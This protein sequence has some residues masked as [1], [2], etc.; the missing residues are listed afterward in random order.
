VGFLA[1]IALRLA[2]PAN[3][4]FSVEAAT[5]IVEVKL[6]AHIELRWQVDGAIVCARDELKL[7]QHYRL[8]SADNPCGSR[9]WRAWRIPDPEQVI[10]LD[11]DSVATMQAQ[12]LG[13]FAISLRSSDERS[14]GGYSV[15]GIVDDVDI[16]A[17]LNLIWPTVPARSLTLPFTGETTLGRAVSWSGSR[18]LLSGSAAVFTSDESADKRSMVEEATLMLGDQV[19]LGPPKPGSPW[20]KGFVR[21]SD[22]DDFMQVVAFGRASSLRIERFG[23]SGYDFK[24]GLIRKVAADP[25]IAFW[26]SIL[27]AYMTL[28]LGLQ[29]FVGERHEADAEQR[30]TKL[31]QRFSRWIRNR[32]VK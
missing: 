7:P 22:G 23:E 14:L 15:I 13:G 5:Q 1:F 18:M 2:L 6:P 21:M 31:L 17:S 28:I 19:R 27:A 25:R 11:G 12:P 32:P 8:T 9:A 16:G 3:W 10:R 4:Q 24:P 30:A 29:P 26:G 20:A